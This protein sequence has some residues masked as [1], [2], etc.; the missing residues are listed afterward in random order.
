MGNKTDCLLYKDTALGSSD[1]TNKDLRLSIELTLNGFSFSV[2]SMPQG[3]HLAVGSYTF[4]YG[5][6]S[7]QR[8]LAA[9]VNVLETE[10][11]ISQL[12]FSTTHAMFLDTE[13]TMLPSELFSNEKASEYLGFTLGREIAPESASYDVVE[14]YGMT[15]VYRFPQSIVD[16]LSSRCAA[17][18]RR[19]SSSVFLS[20]AAPMSL[21]TSIHVNADFGFMQVAVFK[22]GMPVLVN[23]FDIKSPDDFSYYLLSACNQTGTDE[24]DAE[25]VFSGSPQEYIRQRNA[26][27]R[28]FPRR[29]FAVRKH[30]ELFSDALDFVAQ[31]EYYNIL[32]GL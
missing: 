23:V 13:F 18:E 16:Y 27:A 14:K 26:L 3:L 4:R 1:I 6:A 19:H 31:Y 30:P 20:S 2:D 5:Q 10:P 25:F 11:D 17:F 15:C 9:L 28:H 24:K 8:L 21:G 22:D 7:E 29:K 12:T 32:N